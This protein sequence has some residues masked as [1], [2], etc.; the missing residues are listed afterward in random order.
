MATYY[1]SLAVEAGFTRTAA[2]VALKGKLAQAYEHYRYVTKAQIEA[3]QE[4]LKRA[5]ERPAVGAERT[6]GDGWRMVTHVCDQLRFRSLDKYDGLPPAD[7]LEQV[8]A[9][10]ERKIFNDFQVADVAPVATK[11][12]MPDP[13]VFGIIDG[14][15]D[16]FVIAEWGD[17]VRVADLIKPNEG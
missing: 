14:C 9:A 5:T 1:N 17:D 6:S 15:S 10:R 16:R 3:Y 13:I 8:K 2:K 4:K 7:V 11:Y 12:K